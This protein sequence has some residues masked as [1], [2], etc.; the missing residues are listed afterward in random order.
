VLDLETTGLRR[1]DRIV[2]AGLLV[3]DVAHILFARSDHAGVRNLP[4]AEFLEALGPLGRPELVVVAHNARFDLSFLRREGIVVCGEVRDTLKLL[5]LLDQDR[6]GDKEATGRGEPRLDRR[7]PAEAPLHLDYKLKHVCGQL[8]GL[9][10]RHFPGAIARAPYVVH[11]TYLASDLLGTRALYEFLWPQLPAGLRR[12]HEEL[13]APLLP[14]LLDMAEQG[15]CTD[16]AHIEAEC[17]KLAELLGRLAAE[18]RQRHGVALGMNEQQTCDWLF[19]R[20]GLPVLKRRR[21]GRIWVPSLDKEAIRRLTLYTE[22]PAA[23]DSLRR[24]QEYRQATSLLVR[25]RALSRYV[26]PATGRIHSGFDDKQ[27]SGRISSG[28]PNLQQLARARE[29]AGVPVNCRNALKASDGFELVAFDI[30]QADIRVL[31]A[32][33]ETFG[34][35]AEDYLADLRRQRRALLGPHLAA[36]A[37]SLRRC[38]NPAFVGD[39][40]PPPAFRPEDDCRLADA[41][42]TPGDFYSNAVAAMI[43]RSPADKAERDRYK[44]IILAIVNGKGPPSLARDLGCTEA[45]ARHYLEAFAWTYPK[46][47]AFKD[48]MYWQIALTGRTET[49][50]GRVRTVTAHSWLVTEPQVEILVSYRRGKFWVEAVPLEPSRRVL[51]TFVRKAWNARTGR[52]IYDHRRGRLSPRDYALF[53]NAKL[54]YRLPV[55]NWGWRSIRRVRARGEEAAYEGFDATARSA[56]NF[57]CQGG[58][59]DVAKLM[60]LR[61]RPVCAEFGARLLIQ[62]HDELVFEAPRGR[63]AEFVRAMW[64]V[65]EQPPAP[66]FRI[67]IVVEPKWG[68]RFGELTKLKREDLGPA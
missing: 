25:L 29:V 30:A 9:R 42:H 15:V 40:N 10:L 17:V 58:T 21:K 11:A 64:R 53:D 2:S 59:A 24:I 16:Q 23:G 60:M 37:D 6:G 68:P 48:L 4:A 18:H 61:A 38:R 3:D 33:V 63:A 19:C 45:E 44:P 8:L 1:H 26:D 5:R 39:D 54:Q 20:L 65:L 49:F 28:L 52:L 22:D 56:F 51:T 36:H 43:G 32:A 47:M 27:A 7:A 13:V 57:I 62:I 67:P 46:V 12:Y 55:R 34:R 31:A 35:T 14:A 66:S 50:A 41:F